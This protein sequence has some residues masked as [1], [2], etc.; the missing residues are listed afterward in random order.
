MSVLS[1]GLLVALIAMFIWIKW[2]DKHKWETV[3]EAFG[4]Q[5]RQAQ[6]RLS[7]LRGK[8]I[9]CRLKNYAPGTIRMMGMQGSQLSTQST[10][11]LQAYKKQIDEAYKHLSDF[12]KNNSP[13]K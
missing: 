7:Y 9:R 10:V 11:L 2:D 8:G 13:T 3:Y 6:E 12:N 5:A 4:H 1:I